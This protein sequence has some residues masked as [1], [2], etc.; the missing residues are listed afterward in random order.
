MGPFVEVSGWRFHHASAAHGNTGH[1]IADLGSQAS[2]L[3]VAW[4]RRSTEA[5]A[6]R[7]ETGAPRPRPLP[8][9]G[10]GEGPPMER[11]EGTATRRE[12]LKPDIESCFK[13][14]TKT[15]MAQQGS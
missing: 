1:K 11:S 5:R 9:E 6:P 2:R 7:P 4:G 8:S 14:L 10:N 3:P 15:E 12:N 13:L